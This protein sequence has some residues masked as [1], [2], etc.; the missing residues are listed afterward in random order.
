MQEVHIE[1]MKYSEQHFLNIQY[2]FQFL[3]NIRLQ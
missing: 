1:D 2:H 3:D